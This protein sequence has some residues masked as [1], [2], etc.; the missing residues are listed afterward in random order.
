MAHALETLQT[1][2]IKNEKVLKERFGKHL[3]R[4]LITGAKQAVDMAY[5]PERTV[6]WWVRYNRELESRL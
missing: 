5:K 3:A 6:E 4:Q 2:A 1:S